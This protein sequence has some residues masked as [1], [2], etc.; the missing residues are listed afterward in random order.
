MSTF[1]SAHSPVLDLVYIY[2]G[3]PPQWPEFLPRH[4]HNVA[5]R[6]RIRLTRF[7]TRSGWL[8]VTIGSLKGTRAF[9]VNDDTLSYREHA[10][11]CDQLQLGE[12]PSIIFLVLERGIFARF[13]ENISLIVSGKVLL[14]MLDRVY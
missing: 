3:S 8:G 7:S 12:S 9:T 2:A 4:R 6:Q 1:R 13:L 11:F 10:F 14:V 5:G